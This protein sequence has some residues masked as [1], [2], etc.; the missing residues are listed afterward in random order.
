MTDS[1]RK[2][3]RLITLFGDVRPE[4]VA[5][6]SILTA[7][8]FVLLSAYYIL[9]PVREALI[10]AGEGG[11]TNKAYATGAIAIVFTIIAPLY[12]ALA[13]RVAP[14]ALVFRI[15]VFFASHL[16]LFWGLSRSET[17]RPHLGFPFFVWLGVFSM[18]VLAQFWGLA[19]D[20][21]PKDKGERLFPILGIGASLGATVGSQLTAR[22]AA[23]FSTYDL[24]L[25][26]AAA[27]LLAAGLVRWAVQREVRSVATHAPKAA[28]VPSVPLRQLI[29]DRYIIGLAAFHLLFTLANSNGEFLLSGLATDAAPVDKAARHQFILEFYGRFYFWVNAVGLFTQSFLVSRIV[30]HVPLRRALLFVPAISVLNALGFVAFPILSVLFVGKVTEN[31]ADYSL[32]NT[33]RHM[34]WLPT[35]SAAKFKAKQIVDTLFVRVGDI[36]HAVLVFVVVEAMERSGRSVAFASLLVIAI[37]AMVAHRLGRSY[38]DRSEEASGA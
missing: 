19:N 31:S 18:M 13:D 33:L 8:V 1:P 23:I 15:F 14:R 22:L 6:A 24:L 35:S 11:A 7:A 17:Y 29:Q 32:N 4:E 9:K 12:S 28:A 20:L 3:R 38:D 36:L 21:Y 16:V 10:L 2:P 34:L 27:L 30:K 37:W 25:I 26:A 5:T